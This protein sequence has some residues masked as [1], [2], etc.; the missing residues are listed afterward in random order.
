[1]VLHVHMKLSEDHKKLV[2]ELKGEIYPW[3]KY[4]IAIDGIAGSGKSGLSRY[5]A[6]QLDMPTIETDMLR[7]RE[8]EQPAYR[9]DELNNL[10]HARHELNRPVIVEGI[11]LLDT[12]SKL[13]IEP[14]YIIYVKSSEASVGYVL[15]DSLPEY[16]EKQ[17]PEERADYVFN[18]D[19]KDM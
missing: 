3:R 4:L 19:F 7:E 6:W 5:L 16:I 9:L 18:T 8:K 13:G 17:K 1:M 10:I 14:D 12:L 2:S 15:R 11:F